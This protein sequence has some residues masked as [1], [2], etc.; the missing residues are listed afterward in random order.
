VRRSGA[1]GSRP[2]A[3]ARLEPIRGAT[4][5]NGAAAAGAPPSPKRRGSFP[6][7]NNSVHPAPAT[8]V[9]QG[10]ILNDGYM[11]VRGAEESPYALATDEY[12]IQPRQFRRILAS[13]GQFAIPFDPRRSVHVLC[14]PLSVVAVSFASDPPQLDMRVNRLSSRKPVHLD[15]TQSQK[16]YIQVYLPESAE[17]HSEPAEPAAASPTTDRFPTHRPTPASS[18]HLINS[19]THPNPLEYTIEVQ[20]GEFHFDVAVS[21]VPPDGPLSEFSKNLSPLYFLTGRYAFTEVDKNQLTFNP[22]DAIAVLQESDD[23]WYVGRLGNRVG[24]F[25]YSYAYPRDEAVKQADLTKAKRAF[26]VPTTTIPHRPR[27]HSTTPSE[28]SLQ[29]FDQKNKKKTQQQQL[30]R[31]DDDDDDNNNNNNKKSKN[32]TSAISLANSTRSRQG[33]RWFLYKGS[34]FVGDDNN[35]IDDGRPRFY[36][37]LTLVFLLLQLILLLVSLILERG[38]ADLHSNP[39]IGASFS[40]LHDVGARVPNFQKGYI[41][42]VVTA[43]FLPT[44]VL[45]LVFAAVFHYV[46]CWPFEKTHGYLWLAFVYL[47]CGTMGHIA[48]FIFVPNWVSAGPE[49]AMMGVAGAMFSCYLLSLRH[50][51]DADVCAGL[52]YFLIFAIAILLGLL[53]GVDNWTQ[54]CGFC[55]G[56]YCWL[57][58]S[59]W[60]V[61]AKVALVCLAVTFVFE[62]AFAFAATRQDEYCGWCAQ[63]S[64][65]PVYDWCADT[66]L[67]ASS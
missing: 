18:R 21:Q 8:P 27:I 10:P 62:V 53:P 40:S 39:M 41:F 45:R 20:R 55:M 30:Q 59:R 22:G 42:R 9:R 33:S 4:N 64:C 19:I 32:N 46:F 57:I 56:L 1:A 23:G 28:D 61:L 14:V 6:F 36:I 47:V 44:G 38:I 60:R 31:R 52:P 16:I 3:G 11:S 17:A 58:V 29:L 50:V 34:S 24:C 51:R 66:R 25:P 37:S 54:M 2:A 63:A 7:G 35:S 43:N 12:D 49:P 48:G 13:Q 26:P 65:L 15:G 5:N 67:V